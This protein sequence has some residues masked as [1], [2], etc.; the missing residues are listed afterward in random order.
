M[1]Q[2]RFKIDYEHAPR[3][4]EEIFTYVW[5]EQTGMPNKQMDDT[6][7]AI[8]Y[9]IYSDLQVQEQRNQSNINDRLSALKKL[10]F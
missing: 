10:G 8:R 4:R 5:N 1:K 6:Q 7:D 9:A 3:F 2:G